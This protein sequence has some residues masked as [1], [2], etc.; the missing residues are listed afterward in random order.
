MFRRIVVAY[1]GSKG[2]TE[3]LRKAVE[4]TKLC[5][6]ELMVLTVYRHHSMLEASI[7]MV[8]P[9]ATAGTLDDAMREHAEEVVEQG[10]TVAVRL[11]AAGTRAFVKNGPVAR[12][13][14]AFAE[15]HDADLVVLG[16]RGLG[17]MDRYLL[18]SVS[19]KVSGLADVPVLVV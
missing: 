8:R 4:L 17:S 12:G 6:A 18:G 2:A 1:D 9:E 11:G 10:K 5:E 15:E 3:A 14:V 16:S 19:H 7:S 13:I